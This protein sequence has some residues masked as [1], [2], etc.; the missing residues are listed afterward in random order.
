MTKLDQ[1]VRKLRVPPNLGR[2]HLYPFSELE[3]VR[4]MERTYH[5]TALSNKAN[6]NIT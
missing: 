1:K 4:Q 2:S 6:Y 3:F 5:G